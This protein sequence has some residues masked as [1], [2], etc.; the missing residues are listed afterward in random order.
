MKRKVCV[1]VF[2]AFAV[3]FFFSGAM[4]LRDSVRSKREKEANLLLAQKVQRA[5]EKQ[6]DSEQ[7]YSKK[8]AGEKEEEN[9]ILPEYRELWEQNQ[10]LA[11]WLTIEDLGIDYAVMYTPKEPEYYLHRGFSKEEAVSGS[12]FIGEGW[13]P[14]GGNTIIYGHHMKD[15]TMFGQLNEYSSSE[16]AKA[17]PNIRFDTL[18]EKGE[19]QVIA[20]FYSRIYNLEDKDAFRY[21]WYVDLSDRE[22][23]EEFITK[24]K[25]ASIYDTGVEAVYGD[26]LLTLSTCSYHAKEGRFVVIARKTG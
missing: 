20:A 19:Y 1:W 11:G 13:K 9:I 21:Y 14:E 3:L 16:Y 2:S 12:L 10:D 22:R 8:T 17:H 18:T 5:V 23:F 15:G 24:V 26:K 4:L 6:E 25:A 7:G